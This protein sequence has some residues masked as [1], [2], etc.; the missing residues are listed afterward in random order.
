MLKHY[1]Q[2]VVAFAV[3]IV[4]HAYLMI[5]MA[6]EK[7]SFS[8][9]MIELYIPGLFSLLSLILIA[10]IIGKQT[11]SARRFILFLLAVSLSLFASKESGE[12]DPVS[13]TILTVAFQ[14]AAL[15]F[16][17]FVEAILKEKQLDLGSLSAWL[18]VFMWVTLLFIGFNVGNYFVSWVPSYV[19][20]NSMLVHFSFS[21]FAALGIIAW[22]YNRTENT[23]HKSF[24]KW[25][26]IVPA[27]AFV[28]FI[29]IYVL[30]YVAAGV[31]GLDRIAVFSLFALPYGYTRLLMNR[32]LFDFDFVLS[33]FFYYSVQSVI[34][35]F[36]L[37]VII[38]SV[39]GKFIIP[40]AA[41]LLIM[42]LSF[43]MKE[44]F[45][46][47]IRNSL[48]QDR[49]NMV[50]GIEILAGKLS[51]VMKTDELERM[52]VLEVLH[53]LHPSALFITEKRNGEW[54]IRHA[55]GVVPAV[56]SEAH[57]LLMA[58]DRE[59]GLLV[60]Q[61]WLGIQLFERSEQN[62]Y[63]WIGP[64]KNG[65]RWNI[66]EKAWL[67]AGVPYVRLVADN[68]QVAQKKMEELEVQAMNHSPGTIRL[69]L[70]ISEKERRRLAAD[71][72]DSVLQEQFVVQRKLERLARSEHLKHT[73]LKDVKEIQRDM[74]QVTR[75]IRETCQELRPFF[76]QEEGLRGT[77]EELF[78]RFKLTSDIYLQ[79]D[80]DL[81]SHYRSDQDKELAVYRI[82]QELLHNARKHSKASRLSI[83]V[84]EESETL[85]LDYLDNG[86]GFDM[87]CMDEQGNQMGISGIKER[88]AMLS[89]YVEWMTSPNSGV[90]VQMTLPGWRE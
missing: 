56:P 18:S 71:L 45:D 6:A 17:L 5:K 48:F 70:A 88:V 43:L 87:S 30:P 41:A 90:Q 35:A 65:L 78:S 52:F 22:Q 38:Y 72:H 31:D 61:Q 79:C 83:S 76:L 67:L 23:E 66:S 12:G 34:P 42:A 3:Y 58:R 8:S 63:L 21:I 14:L 77:L 51:A 57:R 85:F 86:I 60:H 44:Q 59:K 69:L 32:Q 7:Q 10:P 19:V 29:V 27:I 74:K 54:L 15:Y 11:T 40:F 13:V 55:E 37:A 9:D 1:W 46:F 26:M 89:G 73:L 2:L 4:S 80:I 84:W 47:F 49:K 20:N 36:L 62:I 25:M 28:P 33:R 53:A 75:H 39:A 24:L 64:K 50:Q 68:L 82:V 16:L 81:P